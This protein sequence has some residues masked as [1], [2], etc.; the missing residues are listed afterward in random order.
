MPILLIILS[1]VIPPVAVAMKFGL[2]KDFVINVILTL[3][4]WIPGVIH[5]LYL[6]LKK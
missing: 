5:A 3:L 6:V 2:K 1:I 4:F